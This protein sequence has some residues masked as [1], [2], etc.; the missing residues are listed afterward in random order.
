MTAIDV[1]IFDLFKRLKASNSHGTSSITQS[2]DNRGKKTFYYV[3]SVRKL[4]VCSP[5]RLAEDKLIFSLKGG[6]KKMSILTSF[7]RRPNFVDSPASRSPTLGTL[8]LEM[9][10]LG[11]NVAGQGCT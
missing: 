7:S 6:S 4:S 1:H 2:N 9:F 10:S 11:S 8:P 5:N 3:V